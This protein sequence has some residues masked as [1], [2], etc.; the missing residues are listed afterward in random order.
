[1]KTEGI[2]FPDEII[3]RIRNNL[4]G[5]VKISPFASSLKMSGAKDGPEKFRAFD[6]TVPEDQDLVV[7]QKRYT[8]GTGIRDKGYANND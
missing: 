1:M 7:P 5:P 2:E 3:K 4:Q 8:E 6:I